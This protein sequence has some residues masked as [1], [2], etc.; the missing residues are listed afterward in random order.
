MSTAPTIFVRQTDLPV[1]KAERLLSIARRYFPRITLTDDYIWFKLLAAEKDLERRLRVFFEPRMMLPI[2]SSDA[3]R[4]TYTGANPPVP[5]E[6][7][8]GYDYTPDIFSGPRWGL[9]EVRK[10]PIISI[11][12]ISFTYPTPSDTLYTFPSD[13]I[14]PDLKYGVINLVPSQT[15]VQGVTLNAF[16]LAAFSGGLTVPLTLQ[17]RYM[18]G[19]QDTRNQFPDLV[20]LVYKAAV[21]S[22]LEDQYL[23]SSGSTSGDGL[24]QS[25]SFEYDKYSEIIEKKVGKLKRAFTGVMMSGM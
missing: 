7:E 13:W 18:S 14:R 11:T 10:P 9:I 12:S 17:I 5:V 22:I 19:L 25:I 4:A 15:A 16:V 24:S 1:L 6:L 23:P 2:F 8:P 20:D 3:E 21:L